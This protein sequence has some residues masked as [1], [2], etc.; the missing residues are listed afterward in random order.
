[1]E[2]SQ[3]I[4]NQLCMS[5]GV[6]F[7]DQKQN[8]VIIPCGHTYCLKCISPS[9]KDDNYFCKKCDS[10]ISLPQ[11]FKDDL[12]PIIDQQPHPKNVHK[13]KEESKQ[14]E[15]DDDLL[16]KRILERMVNLL[17]NISIWVENFY[18]GVREGQEPD[19]KYMFD[20]F[21]LTDN[22]KKNVFPQNITGQTQQKTCLCCMEKIPL[23][24]EGIE[25]NAYL[26]KLEVHKL[27]DRLN[28]QIIDAFVKR[29][30]A[31][32]AQKIKDVKKAQKKNDQEAQMNVADIMQ[33]SR[34]QIQ[35]SQFRLDNDVKL[36][37]AILY[38]TDAI[39]IIIRQITL[40]ALYHLNLSF[41]CQINVNLAMRNSMRKLNQKVIIPCGD[42]YCLECLFQLTPY[43]DFFYC[44]S[45]KKQIKLSKQFKDNL[46]NLIEKENKLCLNCKLNQGQNANQLCHQCETSASQ[47]SVAEKQSDNQGLLSQNDIENQVNNS[48]K[49]DMEKLKV[50]INKL[51][52]FGYPDQ[53]VDFD[54][55]IKTE[56]SQDT[57]DKSLEMD[58]QLTNDGKDYRK[59]E[60]NE[61][62]IEEE[63]A[64]FL[65][66]ITNQ[67]MLD[68][69]QKHPKVKE[70]EG[71]GMQINAEKT[72]YGGQWKNGKRH[73]RGIQ[74][75]SN[76]DVYDGE[77]IN[78]MFHGIGILPHS[79]GSKF[80]GQFE[81]NRYNG[82]GIHELSNGDRYEG[83]FFNGQR[84]G[85]GVY[86]WKDGR[87]YEGGWLN[88]AQHGYGV[89]QWDGFKYE[90]NW[91]NNMK[92]GKGVQIDVNG[93]R[94]EGQQGYG[95]QTSANGTKMY[96]GQ[97]K[98]HQRENKCIIF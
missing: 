87:R 86:L 37:I 71:L 26:M 14:S 3:A 67:K 49:E 24:Q 60:Q 66:N 18:Y 55:I 94:Y 95:V 76:G 82:Y 15:V 97:W 23:H 58:A 93:D 5:C 8:Q 77:W 4:E 41:V 40:K 63:Y 54:D 46:K 20:Q 78:D 51:A 11:K 70:K 81:L 88:K 72:F 33:Q 13:P 84:N 74:I 79:I 73:G 85:Q 34:N 65:S 91:L 53:D 16:I 28:M 92:H 39:D 7:D 12:K 32:K 68:K 52:Q 83:C 42:V 17:G 30:E 50:Y 2:S 69:M 48:A 89:Y 64:K 75:Y 96:E 43:N 19:L 38:M 21:C 31:V 90:G 61:S 62:F 80:V 22:D 44:I 98:N 47:Y 6:K 9:L 27:R 56:T 57:H 29:F 45:C 10:S 36:K 25:G 59:K 1:M 35:I